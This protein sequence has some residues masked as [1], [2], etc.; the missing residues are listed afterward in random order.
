MTKNEIQQAFDEL[1]AKYVHALK[2]LMQV[3]TLLDETKGK[4]VVVPISSESERRY[5]NKI[6]QLQHKITELESTPPT[7]VE[8]PSTGDMKETARL[9]AASEFN[10]ED[11][12]QKEIF[13]ILVK[14]SADEVNK[15]L[16]FWAVPLPTASSDN[17]D[18]PR[19]TRKT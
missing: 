14:Q 17:N 10:K 8:R 2:K 13:D 3:Y 19:Y 11:L 15:T 9:L 5:I 4:E 7:E 6:N 18:K 1:N 16:G 12:T